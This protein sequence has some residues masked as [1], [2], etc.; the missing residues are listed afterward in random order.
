MRKHHGMTSSNMVLS[1]FIATI[2]VVMLLVTIKKSSIQDLKSEKRKAAL[3]GVL[4]AIKH[5]NEQVLMPSEMLTTGIQQRS[6]KD[7]PIALMNGQLR[8]NKTALN[9]GLD[10]AYI[11]SKTHDS[12]FLDW[13]ILN[14]PHHIS[15]PVRVKIQQ[16][17]S[18]DNCH[19]MY[20]EAGIVE[21]KQQVQY[22][23]VEHGC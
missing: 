5:V 23:V 15:H 22:Q 4:V 8:A 1:I 17:Q 2:I 19:L 6:I 13:Q 21:K 11:A 16:F 14:V 9:N 7:I 12:T 18:P 20:S 10:L 3:R